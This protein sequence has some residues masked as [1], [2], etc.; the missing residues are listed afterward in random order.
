MTAEFNV[1]EDKMQKYRM[2]LLR[3]DEGDYLNLRGLKGL[4]WEVVLLQESFL[5]HNGRQ[6]LVERLV[7]TH[8]TRRP[9]ECHQCE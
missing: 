8:G 6:R 4:V 5:R 9:L 3:R 2:Q 1:A 7:H